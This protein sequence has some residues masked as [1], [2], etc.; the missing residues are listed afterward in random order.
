MHNLNGR[1]L[2]DTKVL[3]KFFEIDALEKIVYKEVRNIRPLR[4]FKLS[5]YFL[6]LMENERPTYVE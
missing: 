3:G 6:L 2:F 4:C 1:L 5:Y